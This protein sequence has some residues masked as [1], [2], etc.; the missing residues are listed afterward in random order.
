MNSCEKNVECV[1]CI[2]AFT[3]LYMHFLCIVAFYHNCRYFRK[4][5]LRCLQSIL[6]V[7]SKFCLNFIQI[8]PRKRH[9]VFLVAL[10]V[11][12]P[13]FFIFPSAQTVVCRCETIKL[14]HCVSL[15]FRTL[16]LCVL[17]TK[18]TET[19]YP[20]VRFS[21]WNMW[22]I[23]MVETAQASLLYHDTPELGFFQRFDSGDNNPLS[24]GTD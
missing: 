22:Q 10:F 17:C 15:K 1:A 19:K 16:A 4:N 11:S 6:L 13:A 3:T 20:W 21:P 18:W 8:T 2:R 14:L 12:F 5:S 24:S 23:W 9:L 7:L